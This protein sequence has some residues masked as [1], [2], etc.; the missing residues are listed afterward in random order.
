MMNKIHQRQQPFLFQLAG[1]VF[2]EQCVVLKM[3]MMLVGVFF[4]S[5][6]VVYILILFSTTTDFQQYFLKIC[7]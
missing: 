1:L 2:R 6:I 5:A 3:T 7:Y 4:T